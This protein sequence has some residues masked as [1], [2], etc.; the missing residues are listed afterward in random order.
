[1]MSG[2]LARA[3]PADSSLRI[4]HSAFPPAVSFCCTF[5][6]IAPP[7][8]YPAPCPLQFGLS[9][10]PDPF[11]PAHAVVATAATLNYTPSGAMLFGGMT[12]IPSTGD[13]RAPRKRVWPA[14]AV[15]VLVLA[16]GA[17]LYFGGVFPRK[18]QAARRQHEQLL[19]L[20]AALKQYATAHDNA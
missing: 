3:H 18:G 10:R 8:R 19:E 12:R 15:I 16:V 2:R 1:M 13:E 4:R 9:S 20:G 17:A 14:A 6:R 7:G 11:G 5:R